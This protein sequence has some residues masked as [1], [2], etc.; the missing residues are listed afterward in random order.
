MNYRADLHCH[1]T[2]SDGTLTPIEILHLAKKQHLSGLSITDHDTLDAYTN[3]TLQWAHELKVDLFTGV[4]L[5]TRLDHTPL[6]I[7]GYGVGQTEQLLRFFVWQ[8]ENRKQ[9]NEEILRRLEH[10]SLPLTPQELARKKTGKGAGRVHIAQ[11]MVEKGYVPSIHA[12]FDR[13]IGDTKCCFVKGD[14]LNVQETVDIIHQAGGK[15]FIAHPHLIRKKGILDK[16]LQI[17]FDGIECYYSLFPPKKEKKWLDI[18]KQKNWLISG[19]SDF[20]GEIKPLVTLGASWVDEQIVK[21]IFKE[22]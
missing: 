19:G 18:A 2:C 5:S 8:R 3:D 11:L 1:T 22:K 21:K 16:L 9:R 13:Y 7:L 17:N 6:H 15:A 10:R 20:H 14:C 4:E 12:A